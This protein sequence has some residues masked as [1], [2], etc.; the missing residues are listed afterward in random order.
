[1]EEELSARL[2]NA[3]ALLSPDHRAVILLHHLD[4]RDVREIAEIMGCSEGTVKS[5][6]GRARENLKKLLADYVKN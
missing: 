4:G 3:I 2:H 6:L 1:M 5:R